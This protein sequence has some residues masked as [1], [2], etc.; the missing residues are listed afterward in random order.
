MVVKPEAINSIQEKKR[1]VNI[2]VY[3]HIYTSSICNMYTCIPLEY[4]IYMAI[5]KI[6]GLEVVTGIT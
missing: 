1:N 5:S 2:N 3:I 6:L 4:D